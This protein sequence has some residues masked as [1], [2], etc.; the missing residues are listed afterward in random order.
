MT[1][2]LS[3]PFFVMFQSSMSKLIKA[4]KKGYSIAPKFPSTPHP[5]KYYPLPLRVA[6]SRDSPDKYCLS[7]LLSKHTWSHAS[8][9][10]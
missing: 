3:L 10:M 5:K 7:S 4:R 9:H 6:D 1:G 8:P 2:N